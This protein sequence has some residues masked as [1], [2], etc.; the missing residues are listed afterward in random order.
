[1]RRAHL[2]RRRFIRTAGL[3]ITLPMLPSLLHTRGARAADCSQPKRFL[4][5]MFPNG[6]HM[7]EHMPSGT[8]SGF[9]IAV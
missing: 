5:Y 2:S 4:A 9:S 8:G 3:A 6:H 7:P 1:M